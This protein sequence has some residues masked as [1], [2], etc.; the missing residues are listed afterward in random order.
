[1]SGISVRDEMKDQVLNYLTE[2]IEASEIPLGRLYEMSC[3]LADIA[4]DVVGIESKEQDMI[5]WEGNRRE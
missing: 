1:M 2:K 4:F 3:D 5:Y